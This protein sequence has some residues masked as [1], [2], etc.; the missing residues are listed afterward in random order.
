V[1]YATVAQF[2]ERYSTQTSETL[3]TS[4]HLFFASS[5]VD[6]ELGSVFT[7]PFSSNNR[8]ATDLTKDM[9]YIILL[10]E[11]KKPQED[12]EFLLDMWNK[13]VERLRSGEISM[14]TDS[15][16]LQGDLAGSLPASVNQG[17]KPT[18]DNRDVI[19]QRVDPDKLEAEWAED[20]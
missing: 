18:F 10:Q 17:Y 7:T 13:R 6:E 2:K 5:R 19:D 11:S 12:I 14:S 8:T 4:D 20:V 16:A 3:I 9:A 1:S 15:G